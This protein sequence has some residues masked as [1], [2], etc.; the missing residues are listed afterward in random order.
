M[1]SARCA[2]LALLPGNLLALALLARLATLD[3]ERGTRVVYKHVFHTGELEVWRDAALNAERVGDGLSEVYGQS[4]EDDA[5]A[6]LDGVEGDA[7]DQEADPAAT[8][9]VAEAAAA[10]A[11]VTARKE[12]RQQRESVDQQNSADKV[13]FAQAD[14]EERQPNFRG[15]SDPEIGSGLNEDEQGG[16]GVEDEENDLLTTVDNVELGADQGSDDGVQVNEVLDLDGNFALD[17]ETSGDGISLGATDAD[18]AIRA[19]DEG[20]VLDLGI[21]DGGKSPVSLADPGPALEGEA[22]PSFDTENN[23]PELVEEEG[24]DADESDA[25]ANDAPGAL[26]VQV[27]ALSKHTFAYYRGTSC[28]YLCDTLRKD[29]WKYSPGT[30]SPTM[31]LIRWKSYEKYKSVKRSIVNQ[32]GKSGYCI[33]GM[34][35]AQ[36]RC[37]EDFARSFG[38]Q[39][40]DLALGPDTYNLGDAKTCQ[41]FL[42]DPAAADRN[43][44]VKASSGWLGTNGVSDGASVYRG[45]VDLAKVTRSCKSIKRGPVVQEFVVASRKARAFFVVASLHPLVVLFHSGVT[46]EESSVDI[47][48]TAELQAALAKAGRKEVQKMDFHAVDD[49]GTLAKHMRDAVRFVVGAA[50]AQGLES[51]RGRFQVF[52]ADFAV[53]DAPEEPPQLLDVTGEPLQV[54]YPG[55]N[56]APQIWTSLYQTIEQLHTA[57]PQSVDRLRLSAGW[58][59]LRLTD[60]SLARNNPCPAS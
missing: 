17:E 55:A 26:Q 50:Q 4:P 15:A 57:P 20:V 56:L 51:R 22:E 23:M 44:A 34:A 6:G 39:L 41:A 12:R 25:D 45:T 29:K 9:A 40:N 24:E 10:E 53:P 33:G 49:E 28:G 60:W 43:W 36:V 2:V 46:W 21:D 13:E 11:D 18:S 38:C 52:S 48:S 27:R 30:K 54:A 7:S 5:P 42:K 47:S 58:E 37:R 59:L 3:T 14:S 8:A 32:I 31:Y 19:E 16:R 35:Y 1:V